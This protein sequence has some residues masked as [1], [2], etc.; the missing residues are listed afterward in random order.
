MAIKLVLLT[1]KLVPANL[2]S[3][4]IH[5]RPLVGHEIRLLDIKPGS[6][7]EPLEC[8]LSYSNLDP[9]RLDMPVYHALSYV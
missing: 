1:M 2:F 9:K 3:H 5:Y 6:K 8:V 4:E 7:L